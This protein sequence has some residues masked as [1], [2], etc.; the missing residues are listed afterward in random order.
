MPKKLS[1]LL[2]LYLVCL[3]NNSQAGNLNSSNRTNL[4]NLEQ[5]RKQKIEKNK[6]EIISGGDI[7]N[8]RLLDILHT[9]N[10]FPSLAGKLAEPCNA[11][12]SGAGDCMLARD[13]FDDTKATRE[14]YNAKEHAPIKDLGRC[15]YAEHSQETADQA[16]AIKRNN[17]NIHVTSL[18]H[19]TPDGCPEH[20]NHR[21]ITGF[22]QDKS[23]KEIL[24]KKSWD[25]PAKRGWG[26][27]D[28]IIDSFGC[29]HQAVDDKERLEFLKMYSKLIKDSGKIYA[30]SNTTLSDFI[31][32][33]KD[34]ISNL[35]MRVDSKTISDNKKRAVFEKLSEI[36]IESEE[37]PDFEMKDAPE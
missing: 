26:K 32:F 10:A 28:V 33:E 6:K 36:P 5:H 13:I 25:I 12:D 30:F 11:M 16:N 27:F 3:D 9:F 21:I 24:T 31:G 7:K 23:D 15:I 2:V 20:I 1:I 14:T 22:F 29:L 18:T 34:K 4:T 37:I 35:H 8:R 17:K 19:T